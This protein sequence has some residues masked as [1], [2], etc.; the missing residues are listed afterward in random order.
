MDVT[1]RGMEKKDK[2]PTLWQKINNKVLDK[3]NPPDKT[4]NCKNT[5]LNIEKFDLSETKLS[6]K[7]IEYIE[8]L[9]TTYFTEDVINYIYY[10]ISNY[11]N[12]TKDTNLTTTYFNDD[13]KETIFENK[14]SKEIY[15]TTINNINNYKSNQ[16]ENDI[17]MNTIL[18]I[19]IIEW[20]TYYNKDKNQEIEE[21]STLK[22]KYDVDIKI[23]EGV[24]IKNNFKRMCFVLYCTQILFNKGILQ[25]D[26]NIQIII[27]NIGIF[28]AEIISNYYDFF[29]K[30]EYL[31]K[32]NCI[33]LRF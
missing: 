22:K 20:I 30:Q 1:K 7:K 5:K 27:K 32:P 31:F 10:I 14:Y 11:K 24:N 6:T 25:N 19:F 9:E 8:R 15:F 26:N 13:Q 21:I 16:S 33:E 29:C 2:D 17:V 4:E 12:E 28:L 23:N 3:E 18:S